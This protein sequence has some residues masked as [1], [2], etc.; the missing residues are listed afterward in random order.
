MIF[1]AGATGFVGRHLLRGLK[2]GGYRARC[3]VRSEEGVRFCHE[4]GFEACRGDITD[5]KSLEGKLEG[6]RIVIHLVGIIRERDKGGFDKV[7]V[8]GTGNLVDEA[9]ASGTERFFFQ[10]A[11]G[12][13]PGSPFKYLRT[14]AQAEEIV[15]RSGIPY[16]IF[17]PSL[18]IGPGDGFTENVKELLR[19]GPVVPVPGDGE[20]RF[21]PLFIDDWVRCILEVLDNEAFENR[22]IEI[23]G[24]EHLTYNQMLKTI[25][26]EMGMSKPI[27]HVPPAVTK[28]GLPFVGI[29]RSIGRRFGVK[30]PDVSSEQIDLLQTDNITDPDAVERLFGF[31]PAGFEEA[32]RKALG[33]QPDKT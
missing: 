22:V 4:L 7:H 26:K 9:K 17:R 14:K 12:A 3:L 30:M 13:D 10:S 2:A 31:R 25:M 21:Q 24:P 29:L 11:L 8:E 32:I 33:D 16:T 28:A 23:G 1:I 27:L 19:L 5:R 20:A 6:T 15:K 18:I